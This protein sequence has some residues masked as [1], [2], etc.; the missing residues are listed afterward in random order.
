MIIKIKGDKG[1]KIMLLNTTHSKLVENDNLEGTFWLEGFGGRGKKN[2]AYLKRTLPLDFHNMKYSTR[3]YFIH[4][5]PQGT[6]GGDSG[7]PGYVQYSH[8][9]TKVVSIRFRHHKKF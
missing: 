4:S 7:G 6:C 8:G 3:L 5:G 1:K 9:T 2:K